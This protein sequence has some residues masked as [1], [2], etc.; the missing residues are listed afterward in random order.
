MLKELEDICNPSL[1]ERLDRSII[2]KLIGTK[3]KF[4]MGVTKNKHDK[5]SG[6]DTQTYKKENLKSVEF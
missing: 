3:M 2:S 5:L 6:R 4:G 1:K